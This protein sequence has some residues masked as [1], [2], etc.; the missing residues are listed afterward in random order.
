MA[1]APLKEAVILCVV[2]RCHKNKAV[3][4]PYAP[5]VGVTGSIKITGTISIF[6]R[7]VLALILFDII[8]RQRAL[9]CT[10]DVSLRKWWSFLPFPWPSNG[11]VFMLS[12]HAQES[13]CT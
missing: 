2:Q 11:A 8:A 9:A 7:F 13:H 10:V 3:W 4:D 6:S 12:A 1:V 5:K